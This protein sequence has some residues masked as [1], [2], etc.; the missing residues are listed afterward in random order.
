[1]KIEYVDGYWQ[2]SGN[3]A[4]RPIVVEAN[5]RREAMHAYA[6]VYL[7]QIEATLAGVGGIDARNM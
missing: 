4:L 3:G 2:A 6:R 5:N 7:D 1:M